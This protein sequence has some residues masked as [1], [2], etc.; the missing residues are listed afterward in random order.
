[1][2]EYNNFK[3]RIEYDTFINDMPGY[4]DA[5]SIKFACQES[6]DK[7]P[8]NKKL[9]QT[10]VDSIQD[11]Y[12]LL[13][14]NHE[15][16]LI[17]KEF[18]KK[19]IENED[20]GLYSYFIYPNGLKVN[21]KGETLI[22]S[23]NK[24]IINLNV[25]KTKESEIY[26]NI[27]NETTGNTISNINGDYNNNLE[28][29]LLNN[30]DNNESTNDNDNLEHYRKLT[31]WLMK[32][33][34]E[35]EQFKNSLKD[36]AK[37][38]GYLIEFSTYLKWA[39][40]LNLKSLRDIYKQ[41]FKEQKKHLT[42]EEKQQ[43]IH[44]LIKR[45]IS[46][47]NKI[48]SL[49]FKSIG[50]LKDS[51]KINNFILFNRELFFLIN[52]DE[53][54][55][56]ANNEIDYEITDKTIVIYINNEKSSF[57]K[58][59]NI[60]F[61][62][63]YNN[64]Y[65]LKE[66]Y[67]FQKKLFKEKKSTMIFLFNKKFFYN[68]RKCF[69]YNEL[70][71]YF[72]ND[73]HKKDNEEIFDS[74]QKI[75]ENIIN[76]IK[77]NMK[78]FKLEMD[79]ISPLMMKIDNNIDFSYF[80]AFD[81]I[82]LSG[83]ILVKFCNI[84]ELSQKESETLRKRSA[85]LCF[86]KEKILIIFQNDNKSYGQIGNMK[87]SDEQ[88]DFE[89]DYLISIK[90]NKTDK[91][92]FSLLNE[93]FNKEKG[94]NDFY[95]NIYNKNQNYCFELRISDKLV[96]NVLNYQKN[97]ENE[98]LKEKNQ[99]F[100]NNKNQK[101]LPQY[102]DNNGN[103]FPNNQNN[104]NNN[105]QFVNNQPIGTEINN[106][107]NNIDQ[108]TNI[109]QNLNEFKPNP[110]Y[111]HE[112]Q[113]NNGYNNNMYYNV[114]LNEPTK[115]VLNR[116]AN[117]NLKDTIIENKTNNNNMNFMQTPGDGFNVNNNNNSPSNINNMNNINNNIYNINNLNIINNTNQLPNNNFNY[118]NLNQNQGIPQSY[119]FNKINKCLTLIICFFKSDQ[120]IKMKMSR[121]NTDAWNCKENL[122]LINNK[123]FFNS[124]FPLFYANEL[125]NILNTNPNIL[126]TT[127]DNNFIIQ[128][129]FGMIS[130]NMKQ[131]LS[132]LNENLILGQLITNNSFISLDQASLNIKNEYKRRLYDFYFLSEEFVNQLG[133]FFCFDVKGYFF[134]T[135]CILINQ[136][137]F[138]FT[139]DCAIYIGNTRNN[140]S[141]ITENI[142]Y[143]PNLEIKNDI[144][145][146]IQT[147]G[148]SCYNFLLFSGDLIPNNFNIRILNINQNSLKNNMIIQRLKAFI[149]FDNFNK[150]LN[151]DTNNSLSE[152]E[153]VII[154]KDLFNKMR[155]KE[156]MNI[157]NKY[158]QL[159]ALDNIN[160]NK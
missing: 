101:E 23:H 117:L 60:F 155:Y 139:N 19:F 38:K 29:T 152:E 104:N 16:I 52:D 132:N 137:I 133:I 93:A 44:T 45:K 138:A 68:Y 126:F 107:Q 120:V 34:I 112:Q 15:Y 43:I 146:R 57:P 22:F 51:N 144:M 156:I 62:Y 20:E 159:L 64:I 118:Q 81:N 100:E 11:L 47:K 149:Y 141:F 72:D 150:K 6:G 130:D 78:S 154:K 92:G 65:L 89:I 105:N 75:P 98:L 108:N 31:E 18:N 67:N 119:D 125:Y 143:Y 129:I 58:S 121:N 63:L 26:K 28:E 127:D 69:E 80:N 85:K 153:I 110:F 136:K 27:N 82:L 40:E 148:M 37:K 77:E 3:N 10:I 32:Y 21:I 70:L 83:G 160:E 96:L 124:F 122:Y 4:K 102:I 116:M 55:L 128:N 157:I 36:K 145:S 140:F 76:S 30:K 147:D 53:N 8:L 24:N 131:Y 158:I 33:F 42:E 95:E 111:Y 73:N 99:L 17:N 9:K 86:I 87:E 91:N 54:N 106:T 94:C 12:H 113:Q 114:N 49:K 56:N 1:M 84:H 90:E 61:S 115:I 41:Y 66:I 35:E 109:G 74:I 88:I 46:K 134:K 97:K 103:N 5:M 2:E 7:T 151:L 48:L 123:W 50:E 13:K 39:K 25:L 135:E 71:K 142:I 59:E 79:E 14:N